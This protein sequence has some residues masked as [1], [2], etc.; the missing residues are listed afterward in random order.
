M[1]ALKKENVA[2]LN[3]LG[4]ELYNAGFVFNSDGTLSNYQQ[5]I[6]KMVQAANNITDGKKQEKEIERIN[7]LIE[8][9]EK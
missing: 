1:A 7:S 5:Q 6:D 2:E 3:E 9:I 4:K 8:S